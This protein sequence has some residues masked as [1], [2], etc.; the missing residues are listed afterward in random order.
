VQVHKAKLWDGREVAVKVQYV[1]LETAVTADFTTLSVLAKAA[2]Q[3][4][5]DSF[6]FG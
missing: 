1:G 6:D 3:W 4:F 2:A 5:P